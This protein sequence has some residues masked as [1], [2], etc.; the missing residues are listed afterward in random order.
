MCSRFGCH[1]GLERQNRLSFPLFKEPRK[2]GGLLGE[3]RALV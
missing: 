2:A 1:R 3:K